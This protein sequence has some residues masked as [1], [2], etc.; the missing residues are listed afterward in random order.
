MIRR[1]TWRFACAAVLL[2]FVGEAQAEI[3]TVDLNSF[4]TGTS[5]TNAVPGLT[6]SQ[7]DGS[8]KI[9]SAV[10]LTG[11]QQFAIW[12]TT[13]DFRH[14]TSPAEATLAATLAA[15][16]DP[17][18]ILRIDFDK[19][20]NF[21]SIDLIPNDDNDPG[22]I[23]AFDSAGNLIGTDSTL[24][25][26]LTGVP[27]TLTVSGPGIATLLVGGTGPQTVQV[28]TLLYD[29]TCPEPASIAVWGIVAA[30][31]GISVYRR[32]KR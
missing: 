18:Y 14:L 9:T 32:R 5:L 7:G 23:A 6:I 31:M 19:P 20:T 8:T 29:L 27:I 24:G 15:S 30:V 22:S 2:A 13:G 3:I 12:N 11:T 10:G 25:A 28:D 26:G 4:S 21:V 1:I 17:Q 16:A